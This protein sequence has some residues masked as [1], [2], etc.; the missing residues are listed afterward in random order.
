MTLEKINLIENCNHAS[1]AVLS[2]TLYFTR[3]RLY[4]VNAKVFGFKEL[5]MYSWATMV[6]LTSFCKPVG[7]DNSLANKRNMVEETLA[8]IFLVS[9]SDTPNPC[10]FTSEPAEHRFGSMRVVI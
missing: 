1:N 3:L 2:T 7:K 6:W 8:V 4:G 10:H 9:R 5:V